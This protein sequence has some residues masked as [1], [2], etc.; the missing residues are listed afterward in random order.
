MPKEKQT[1]KKAA[2]SASKTL[3]DELTGKDSKSGAGSAMSQRKAPEKK[4]SEATA[5]S[6]SD[7]LNDGR[8]NKDSKTASGSA[9]SQKEGAKKSSGSK[10][11]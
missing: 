1:G 8:T 6:A 4:T 11:K 10:K 9:M 3:Q 7:V 2:T 5:E